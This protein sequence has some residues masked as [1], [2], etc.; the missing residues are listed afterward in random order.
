[1]T[2]PPFQIGDVIRSQ[3]GKLW[4]VITAV[5]PGDDPRVSKYAGICFYNSTLS[6]I[7]YVG[8]LQ[9]PYTWGI[10]VENNCKYEVVPWDDVPEELRPAAER[11]LQYVLENRLST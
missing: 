4:H 3:D 9:R 5:T 10:Y 1:M 6:H 7:G 11:A 2:R 8:L